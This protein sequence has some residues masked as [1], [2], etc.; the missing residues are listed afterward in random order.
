MKRTSTVLVLSD[1]PVAAA[2]L[3][4]LAES[5]GYSTA[6]MEPGEQPDAALVRVHPLFVVL[7][8][9][10]LHA[11]GSDLFFGRAARRHVGLAVLRRR[12]DDTPL[13]AWARD[14]DV[15]CFDI[16]TGTDQFS[17]VIEAAVESHWWR[18]GEDR[19]SPRAE[20]ADDGHLTL[21]DRAGRRWRVYDRRGSD[22]RASAPPEVP[23][24][25]QPDRE[26]RP[27]APGMRARAASAERVFVSDTGTE[28]CCSLDA[29]ELGAAS[30]ETLSAAELERQLAR[31]T[32][33]AEA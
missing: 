30:L 31:A 7:L 18:S 17:R 6:F 24:E 9:G 23:R 21:V 10:S 8:D 12:G 25:A 2:L 20:R 14:R 33:M 1:D 13:A 26:K 29:T 16:P 15:P 11:A 32:R 3:G 5:A 22:R 28:W 27:R 4:L 19:R